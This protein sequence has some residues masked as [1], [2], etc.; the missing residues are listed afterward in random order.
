MLT[1]Y[2]HKNSVLPSCEIANISRGDAI[3]EPYI[4]TGV[5]TRYSIRNA[6]LKVSLVLVYVNPSMLVK[7]TITV[8]MDSRVSLVNR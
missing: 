5:L 1:K 3:I 7:F 4:I 6:K 2:S 8:N